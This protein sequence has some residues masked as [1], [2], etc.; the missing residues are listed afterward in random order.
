MLSG[1]PRRQPAHPSS[2]MSHHLVARYGYTEDT[3]WV[4]TCNKKWFHDYLTGVCVS[5]SGSMGRAWC[6]GPCINETETQ[7]W[8]LL[9]MKEFDET[10]RIKGRGCLEQKSWQNVLSLPSHHETW[11]EDFLILLVSNPD[12]GLRWSWCSL[13]SHQPGGRRRNGL[14]NRWWDEMKSHVDMDVKM[15]YFLPF[16]DKDPSQWLNATFVWFIL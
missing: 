8:L 10:Q 2:Q 7:F 13:G 5:K 16:S 15:Y 11:G 14:Q 9:I 6:K 4:T 1:A 12:L 3:R